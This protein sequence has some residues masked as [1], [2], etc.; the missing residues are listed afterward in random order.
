MVIDA[1][2]LAGGLKNNADSDRIN[3]ARKLTDEEKIYIP[4]IGEDELPD[5]V[6]N[7]G[8]SYNSGKV[9][10]NS[11][12]K[13][14]LVSL[15]GIGSVLADRILEYRKQHR[16]EAIEDIMNVSGIGDKKFDNIKELII[17]K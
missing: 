10:I 15:P 4:K 16:F 9:N 1:V 17:I 5:E 6:S 2:N 12:S 7:L 11:C 8:S 13:E 3:L 14:E